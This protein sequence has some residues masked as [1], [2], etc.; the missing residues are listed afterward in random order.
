VSVSFLHVG[1]M[2]SDFVR[3]AANAACMSSHGARGGG[4]VGGVSSLSDGGG[5]VLIVGGEVSVSESGRGDGVREG[6]G[7]GDTETLSVSVGSS[8]LLAASV[9][10]EGGI[11]SPVGGVFLPIAHARTRC[12]QARVDVRGA[13]G[14]GGAGCS[15][16][17]LLV[18]GVE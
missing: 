8:V 7:E 14:G 17:R 6:D 12:K 10:D 11:V 2:C 1:G 3:K 16:W 9:S 5:D 15:C 18:G 4:G 13:C